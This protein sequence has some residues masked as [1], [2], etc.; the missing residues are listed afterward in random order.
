MH[1]TYNTFA[2]YLNFTDATNTQNNTASSELHINTYGTRLRVK[3]GMFSV[4]NQNNKATLPPRNI[5]TIVLQKGMSLSVDV[6]FLAMEYE[7]P[8]FFQNR[9]GD[10]LAR[11]WSNAY[12][13]ISSIRLQQANWA[14][15]EKGFIWSKNTIK[16]KMENQLNLIINSCYFDYDHKRKIAIYEDRIASLLTHLNTLIFTPDLWRAQLRGI[17]GKAAN[18]YFEILNLCI[19]EN[20]RFEHR[21]QHPAFDQ[22]NAV[23]NYLYGILYGKIESACIKAGIDP[24]L[25]LFHASQHKKPSFVYDFI[26][27]YRT[28]ADTVAL[29]IFN[30]SEITKTLFEKD[31]GAVWLSGS[32]RKL[33][34]EQFSLY[35]EEL[36][37]LNN[38]K[39]SRNTHIQ[40]DAYRFATLLKESL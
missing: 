24:T 39:R 27:P 40:E 12:G 20:Y 17:E 9:A 25:P 18:F 29:A 36:C 3:D 5:S 35:F 13:S 19:P 23:L 38:R 22:F 14:S 11:V 26:E 33:C 15:N 31:N 37:T 6:V 21:S 32:G 4:E 30:E 10:P 8:I 2:M 28:W 7:I 1:Q 16:Q 34:I